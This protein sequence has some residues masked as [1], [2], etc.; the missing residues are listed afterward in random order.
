MNV[1]VGDMCTCLKLA[2]KETTS[3]HSI[4]EECEHELN[5]PTFNLTLLEA[6]AALD[7]MKEPTLNNEHN[8]SD[9][10]FSNVFPVFP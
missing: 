10:L 5:Y 6:T 1:Q 3:V 4:S 8:Y 7:E 2:K 9:C